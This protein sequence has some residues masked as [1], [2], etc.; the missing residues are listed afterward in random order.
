MAVGFVGSPWF[1]DT[2]GTTG[3]QE[4]STKPGL[5]ALNFSGT[6]V[7]LWLMTLAFTVAVRLVDQIF[8]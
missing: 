5:S 8:G 1:Q 6:M 2:K 4:I 7:Q 3:I